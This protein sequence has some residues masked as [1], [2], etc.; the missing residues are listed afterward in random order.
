M[1]DMKHEYN[2]IFYHVVEFMFIFQV[3]LIINHNNNYRVKDL[4]SIEPLGMR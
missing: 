3:I 1:K 2:T 4:P